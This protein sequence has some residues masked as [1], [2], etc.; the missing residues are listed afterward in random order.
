MIKLLNGIFAPITTPF[1]A[2]DSIN[3]DHLIY[4]IKKYAKTHLHGFLILGSNGENKSLNIPEKEKIVNTIVK[5]K[6]DSQ[7]IIVGSIF[8]STKETIEFSLI[9]E[10]AGADYIALLPPSY[11][12][13]NMKDKV[14]IKYFTDVASSLSIPCIL[15]KAPQFSGGVDL[16]MELLKECASHP[17]IIG[18]KD[19]SP[20]GIEK[21]LC[22]LPKDFL[23]LAGSANNFLSGMLQGA[24]GG[25]LS[26]ANYLP[27]KAV[28]LYQNIIKGKLNKAVA[29]NNT[30]LIYNTR[31]SG[32]YGVAGVKCA[33]DQ[34]G[35]FGDFPRLPLLPLKDDDIQT[36]KTTLKSI[37][38]DKQILGVV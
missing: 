32:T 15:Y 20:H 10:K 8:E 21:L 27:E 25:V 23:V 12:K 13:S 37:T 17:N 9:A 5:H 7:I 24:V 22:E 3:Y 4:N 34:M 19:S 11:F 26:L 16:S 6:T 31:I 29:L 28:D 14:L 18:I 2:D 36:I 33:M 30:I 1:N 35:Y 38:S